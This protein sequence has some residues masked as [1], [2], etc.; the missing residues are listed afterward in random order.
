MGTIELIFVPGFLL[1]VGGATAICP[2]A[3]Q[4][5]IISSNTCVL[6]GR[7]TVATQPDPYTIVGC[8]FTVPGPK[9]QSCVTVKWLVPAAR[10]I[11]AA[12]LAGRSAVKYAGI[13]QSAEQSPQGSPSV[14]MTQV[15]VKAS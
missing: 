2:H 10:V 15:R 7:Q 13:C 12:L 8:T 1:H 14:I 5:A 6:V 9:P 4:V 3:R 11:V